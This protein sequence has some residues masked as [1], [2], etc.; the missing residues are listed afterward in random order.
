MLSVQDALTQ[1]RTKSVRFL[2]RTLSSQSLS[3]REL[4]QT[5]LIHQLYLST[6]GASGRLGFPVSGV[7]FPS[8][9][10]AAR[11]FRGG[12]IKSF[13][14]KA[15]PL[16]PTLEV[17]I[18]FLGARCVREATSDQGSSHDEPYFIVAVI[19]GS[20]IPEVKKFGPFSVD[21]GT[22][23][24][25]GELITTPGT[26]PNPLT[27]RAIVY[28][29]DFGDPDQTAKNIQEKL[30]EISRQVGSAVEALAGGADGPGIGPAATGAAIGG[31]LGGPIGALLVTGIVAGL[32]LGD[33]FVGQSIH[34]LFERLDAS[35]PPRLGQFQGNDFNMRINVNG[36]V[37]G[38]Y[39]LFFDVFVQ[40]NP[41]PI[42]H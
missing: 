12:A 28:E 27:V 31:F 14:D 2:R 9:G 3:T 22:E 7:Q 36:G 32:G 6:G 11:H 16:L 18:N 40:E 4:L 39:D 29:N 17:K 33:D 20:N 1:T 19:N 23:I 30:A 34:R 38:E 26:P 15:V 42:G 5:N 41:I 25:I 10:E 21:S 35:S 8:A 13:G 24:G 37:E